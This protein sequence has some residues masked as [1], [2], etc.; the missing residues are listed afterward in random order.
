VKNLSVLCVSDHVFIEEVTGLNPVD[1]PEVNPPHVC[2]YVFH[3]ITTGNNNTR[4][5]AYRRARDYLCIQV[6]RSDI[7]YT[8]I[9]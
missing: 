4:G 6:Y 1:F 8:S 9:Y 3:Q 7:Y 5:R 2:M